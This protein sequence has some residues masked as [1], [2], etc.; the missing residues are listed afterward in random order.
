MP[1]WQFWSKFK[2]W[3]Y[4]GVSRLDWDAERN[5]RNRRWISHKMILTNLIFLSNWQKKIDIQNFSHILYWTLFW[6]FVSF[7]WRKQNFSCFLIPLEKNVL[8]WSITFPGKLISVR[9]NSKNQII[10]SI[11]DSSLNQAESFNEPYRQIPWILSP[12]WS[13]PWKTYAKYMINGLRCLINEKRKGPMTHNENDNINSNL[14]L[15]I[16]RYWFDAGLIVSRIVQPCQSSFWSRLFY[17]SWH[18]NFRICNAHNSPVSDPA[19]GTYTFRMASRSAGL[20]TFRFLHQTRWIRDLTA[21]SDRFFINWL[22]GQTKTSGFKEKIWR[23]RTWVLSA[24][25]WKTCLPFQQTA[26]V[27]D[28][29]EFFFRTCQFCS[30]PFELYVYSKPSRLYCGKT[31]KLR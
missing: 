12:Q 6:T 9:G 3:F 26:A 15:L 4:C 24:M 14:Y 23:L 2:K 22:S 16:S 27:D 18:V 17:E 30:I 21:W 31:P 7:L 20:I 5:A 28:S 8:M 10:C 11:Q 1:F 25:T 29:Q 13:L 19:T